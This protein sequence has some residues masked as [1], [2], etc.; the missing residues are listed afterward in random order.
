MTTRRQFLDPGGALA[1]GGGPLRRPSDPHVEQLAAGG[2]GF[3]RAY[4]QQA[5]CAPSRVSSTSG[6]RP[7]NGQGWREVRDRVKV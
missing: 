6:A 4:C 3:D 2:L 7:D 1:P 5:V